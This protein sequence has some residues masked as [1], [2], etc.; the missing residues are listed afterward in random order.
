MDFRGRREHYRRVARLAELRHLGFKGIDIATQYYEMARWQHCRAQI[1]GASS[2]RSPR[3]PAM[4]TRPSGA[5]GGSHPSG[6]RHG[7]PLT[8]SNAR[9]IVR[10]HGEGKNIAPPRSAPIGHRV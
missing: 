7:P 2:S 8:R 10:I 1:C 5:D 6:K 4:R 9:A 3:A